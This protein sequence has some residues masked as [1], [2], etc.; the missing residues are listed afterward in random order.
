MSRNKIKWFVPNGAQEKFISAI[1]EGDVFVGIFSGANSVG[2]SAL[3][4]NILGSFIFDNSE[5]P[6]FDYPIFKDFPYPNKG[7]II[8]TTK[9]VEEIGAIQTEVKKWWPVGKYETHKRGKRYDSEY[10]AGDWVLDLMTYEQDPKEFEGA[11][12]GVTIFDEPPPLRIL[13][14][15]IARMRKGGIILIFMTPLDTGG[16]VI[17]DLTTKD[18]VEYEGEKIGKVYLQYA[19]IEE[20]CKEHGIRGQLEHKHI[21]NMLNFYDP[22]EKDARAKGKP[23]HLTGRIY[24]DFEKKDPYVVEDFLIPED[25]TRVC[26]L[27]PHDAIPFALSWAAIDKTGQV[28]IYD[29]FPLEDLEK[30]QVTNLT[31]L[32]YARI[33]RER[34]GRDKIS[35]RL[36]DPYFANKRYSNTGKTVK[37]ELADLGLDFEDGDTSGLDLGHKRVREYLRYDKTKPISALNHSKLHIF[38]RCRNH[39]RSMLRYKRKV[40]KSGEVKDKIKIDETY[41]HFCDNIR[42]LL[43]RRDLTTIND[44]DEGDNPRITFV[45]PFKDPH[46]EYDEGDTPY[47]RY[48]KLIHHKISDEEPDERPPVR[49]V[50]G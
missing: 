35:L 12:L 23:V 34:E 31:F 26:I 21:L 18:E 29:E 44:D 40:S 22:E 33:I 43:M 25:W 14:A 38:E 20:N 19:E 42:H 3:L 24:S 11:T 49:Y 10:I 9:N 27:D 4:V 8:S 48:K 46:I 45:G 39:W 47:D 50:M 1:G 16:E 7:R 36:I 15:S 2:K 17:E 28:W 37:E 30:I 32:D 5:N 13:Y 41:K 6:W